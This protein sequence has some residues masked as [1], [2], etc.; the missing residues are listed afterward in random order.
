[1]LKVAYTLVAGVYHPNIPICRKKERREKEK[2]ERKKERKEGG[3]GRERERK[4]EGR[5]ERR[6]EGRRS[7]AFTWLIMGES[8]PAWVSDFFF[9]HN[10]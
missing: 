3:K 9:G 2:E 6:K 4:K 7:S 5:K 1:M 10:I 8:L